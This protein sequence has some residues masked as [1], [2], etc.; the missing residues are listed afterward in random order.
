[1]DAY[2]PL[3]HAIVLCAVKLALTLHESGHADRLTESTIFVRPICAGKAPNLI[4]LIRS[5]DILKLAC[6]I[7]R[8][9]SWSVWIGM[10]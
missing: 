9:M 10:L 7:R 5:P 1:M 6:E 3:L 8:Q 4:V 2:D